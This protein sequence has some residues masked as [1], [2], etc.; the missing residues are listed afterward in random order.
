MVAP[1]EDPDVDEADPNIYNSVNALKINQEVNDATVKAAFLN[2]F[3]T[4][5]ANGTIA[6]VWID[7]AKIDKKTYKYFYTENV[8]DLAIYELKL[9][10]NAN[11]GKYHVKLF[12]DIARTVKVTFTDAYGVVQKTSELN[13]DAGKNNNVL[14]TNGLA[15]GIYNV[16]IISEKNTIYVKVIVNA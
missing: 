3:K 2:D 8:F 5:E 6:K 7:P 15:P 12:S 9:S 13:L 11:T 4:E 14:N 10:I 16:A 1:L